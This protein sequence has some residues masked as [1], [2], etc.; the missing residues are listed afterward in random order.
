MFVPWQNSTNFQGYESFCKVCRKDRQTNKN[1]STSCAPA[2]LACWS[3]LR[4]FRTPLFI[5]SAAATDRI[6]SLLCAGDTH[7]PR[8]SCCALQAF[9]PRELSASSSLPM[10]R[11]QVQHYVRL[12]VWTH[13]WFSLKYVLVDVFS[14]YLEVVL[15]LNPQ[16]SENWVNLLKGFQQKER[17]PAAFC[18]SSVMT[19]AYCVALIGD[20][21]AHHVHVYILFMFRLYTKRQLGF[22]EVTYHLFSELHAELVRCLFNQI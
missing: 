11:L 5:G 20:L 16:G 14:W 15:L 1:G 18:C 22:K 4:T 13:S 21:C 3:S 19:A 12:T 8:P 7:E 9:M 17:S 2:T 6:A 10:R